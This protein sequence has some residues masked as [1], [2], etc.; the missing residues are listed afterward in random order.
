MPKPSEGT[1]DEE[2][3][4]SSLEKAV[5]EVEEQYGIKVDSYY[6]S[7][8]AVG[9]DLLVEKNQQ[10]AKG[11]YKYRAGKQVYRHNRKHKLP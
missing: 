1:L 6:S 11:I 10:K 8:C 9:R 7:M 5:A 4:R 3:W 2:Q